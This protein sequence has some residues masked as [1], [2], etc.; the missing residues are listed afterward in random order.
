MPDF[1]PKFCP[2]CATLLEERRLADRIRPACPRCEFVHYADPKVA[3]G[4]L[5]EEG[6]GR[7]LYTRRNHEPKLGA[8]AFPSGF[9]DRGEDVREAAVREVREETGL[10]VTLDRLLGVFSRAGEPVI[11]IVFRAHPV[12]GSL[13][14]GPEA[15]AVRFFPEAGLP[16]AAFPTD[17]E[18]LAAWRASRRSAG[19]G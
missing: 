12:G 2:L 11:F 4:V 15:F 14:P 6:D 8:W 5:V 19:A 13:R 18:V 3:V 7:L 16:P 9:V 17:D 1:D 10:D